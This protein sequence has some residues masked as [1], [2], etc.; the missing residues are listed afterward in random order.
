MNPTRMRRSRRPLYALLS[1]LL[2]VSSIAGAS[3]ATLEQPLFDEAL[4]VSRQ[5][6]PDVDADACQKAFKQL[7]DK[8]RAALDAARLQRP[9]HALDAAATVAVLNQ[10]ILVGREV[11]YISNKYWRDSIFTSALLK[12]RGNCAATSLL[13]Y[14]AAR[15]LKLPVVMVFLPQHAMVRWDDGTTVINIETTYKGL[16][17]S[18]DEILKR[19][20]LT[21]ED[22]EPNRFL[23]TLPPE[24]IRGR[25]RAMWS[26]VLFSLDRR[27]E[28][29]TF[30]DSARAID[31]GCPE[32]QMYE[33]NFLMKEGEI[34]KARKIF[35]AI[36]ARA[37]GP[38]AKASSKLSY[39]YY[40]ESRGKIDEALALL[41][42]EY[43][44]AS[45]GMKIK[46]AKMLGLLYRHKHDYE[47]ALPFY[48]FV[49]REEMNA[50]SLLNLGC[51]LSEAHRNGPAITMLEASL[52]LNPEKFN[53]Q[54]ELA[55]LYDRI[56]EKEK[57]R[58]LFAAI[59][60]PRESKLHWHR[61]LAF[62]FANIKDEPKMLEHMDAAFKFDASGDTYQYFVR[63][64]E[65]DPYRDHDGFKKLMDAHAVADTESAPTDK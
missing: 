23:L 37:S 28:A 14:L 15:E 60:E 61:S 31:P 12:N 9:G 8:I 65:M 5:L 48:Q 16:P 17:H 2:V 50:Q 33:A 41:A 51:V 25:L 27:T 59:E 58:A 26:S 57:S 4:A 1:A 43:E 39:A 54:I 13:Y 38:W 20:G 52:R 40:L 10:E 47:R 63:E 18:D 24:Q 36:I 7:T 30:L 35:D 56:G 62:Y 34:T 46:L 53:T 19:F 55:V 32:L 29:R 22:L 44:P 3:D 45:N 21:R 64:Q 42:G 6:D 11:S 49:V